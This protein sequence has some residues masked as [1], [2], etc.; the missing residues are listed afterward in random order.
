MIDLTVPWNATSPVYKKLEDGPLASGMP[1]MVSSNGQNWVTLIKETCYVYNFESASWSPIIVNQQFGSSSVLIG[2][3]GA[4]DPDTGLIYIP[5]ALKGAGGPSMLRLNITDKSYQAVPMLPE[6]QNTTLK[7]VAWSAASKV[8][9]VHFGSPDS[10]YLYSPTK[11]WSKN[12]TTGVQPPQRN[13]PCLVP[14]DGGKKII[15]YGGY[16]TLLHTTFSDLYILDVATL[17]WTAGPSLPIENSRYGASCGVSNDQL[18]VWGGAFMDAASVFTAS[19]TPLIYNL[20]TNKWVSAYTAPSKPPSKPSASPSNPSNSSTPTS[21]PN[22]DVSSTPVG[23]GNDGNSHT[24]IILGSVIGALV[25]IAVI[26]GFLVYR[27]RSRK[28][29][30]LDDS[31][32]KDEVSDKDNVEDLGYIPPPRGI[33]CPLPS[34]YIKEESWAQEPRQPGTQRGPAVVIEPQNREIHNTPVHVQG[35]LE[36]MGRP[37][38]GAYGARSYAQHPH[39]SA[40]RDGVQGYVQGGMHGMQNIPQQAFINK[41]DPA[42]MD[43]STNAYLVSDVRSQ[44][45][46]VNLDHSIRL[47]QGTMTRQPHANVDHSVKYQPGTMAQNPHATINRQTETSAYRIPDSYQR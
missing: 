19:S 26:I 13:S 27:S 18:I 21:S 34:S 38:E 33:P 28:V 35:N 7:R 10:T 37:Q 11:G 17:T 42:G 36:A 44:H 14:A 9:M 12:T 39:T 8:M 5:N 22:S 31:T 4:T 20:K 25:V 24:V 29:K 47:Q 3:E 41:R 43:S 15:M 30:H 23:N 1:S 16:S 45:P 40:E 6:I 32:H 2:L 46:H